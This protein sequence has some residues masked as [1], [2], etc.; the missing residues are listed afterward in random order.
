MRCDAH[1]DPKPDVIWQRAQRKE[2]PVEHVQNEDGSLTLHK[3]KEKDAGK[4][5]CLARNVVG[6][7]R[8]EVVLTVHSE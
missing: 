5:V 8:R 6:S 7:A 1:G 3:V 2:I 4:Y